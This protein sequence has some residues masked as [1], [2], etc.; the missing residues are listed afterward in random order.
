LE[1]TGASV[2]TAIMVPDISQ[3]DKHATEQWLDQSY[4]YHRG[5]NFSRHRTSTVLFREQKP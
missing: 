3:A 5:T 2:G 1:I 4:A